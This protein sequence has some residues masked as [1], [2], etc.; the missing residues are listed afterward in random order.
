[1]KRG[2]GCVARP[3]LWY[4][5]FFP[6]NSSFAET[7]SIGH[8]SRCWKSSAIA[9][10][11]HMRHIV[12]TAGALRRYSHSH[13]PMTFTISQPLAGQKGASSNHLR[14]ALRKAIR[15]PP[16]RLLR[17]EIVQ[18]IRHSSHNHR[19][20]QGHR[21]F[22]NR[23]RSMGC[24]TSLARHRE[25]RRISGRRYT[26]YHKNSPFS[27]LT[28]M[29]I[30]CLRRGRSTLLLRKRAHISKIHWCSPQQ[31]RTRN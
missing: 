31:R 26:S 17:R 12:L 16:I 8:H 28:K 27:P 24:R 18:R 21:R 30:R 20:G 29:G 22:S 4:G 14:A 19:R 1:M 9:P 7:V 6:K 23:N 11:I 25:R 13:C 5:S 10:V 15:H 3:Q 2:Q